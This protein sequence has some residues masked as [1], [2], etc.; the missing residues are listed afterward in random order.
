MD[1]IG[2]TTAGD[3]QRGITKTHSPVKIQEDKLSKAYGLLSCQTNKL[4]ALTSTVSKDYFR[5]KDLSAFELTLKAL[6]STF[7][8]E[9]SGNRTTQVTSTVTHAMGVQTHPAKEMATKPSKPKIIL[10]KSLMMPK[11][12]YSCCKRRSKN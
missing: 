2:A 8:G 4:E 9:T 5:Y 11:K 10:Y 7:P 12:K 3:Q 1:P 6:L